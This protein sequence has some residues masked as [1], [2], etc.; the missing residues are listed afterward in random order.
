MATRAIETI[1]DA[2]SETSDLRLGDKGVAKAN[3]YVLDDSVFNTPE[4]GDY[5]IGAVDTEY[6]KYLDSFL[7]GPEKA[8]AKKAAYYTE[9]P[10]TKN[11]GYTDDK[12]AVFFKAEV[13]NNWNTVDGGWIN[14]DELIIK[15]GS[16]STD[17]NNSKEATEA[18]AKFKQDLFAD[19]KKAEYDQLNDSDYFT[20]GLYGITSCK[21][22]KWAYESNVP[23]GTFQ[24][25]DYTVER[26]YTLSDEKYNEN[27]LGSD[28][29]IHKIHDDGE[30]LHVVK[31]GNV[32][33]EMTYTDGNPES[34]TSSFRW[35]I[36]RGEANHEAAF[37]AAKKMSEILSKV[38]NTVYIM[39]D[40]SNS[41]TPYSM[42][43]NQ[44][45]LTGDVVRK[46]YPIAESKH[47]ALNGYCLARM[48]L[49]GK[50]LGSAYVKIDGKWCN[51]AKMVLAETDD[52]EAITDAD[53]VTDSDAFK[54]D[55]NEEASEWADAF[56]SLNDEI[57]DRKAIQA[58]IFGKNWDDLSKWTVTLGD[59][60][61][62]APPT[63]ITVVS[64]TEDE[65]IPLMRANGSMS[66]MGKR[67]IRAITMELYFTK[68]NEGVNGY[69]YKTKMPN[70]KPI[71]YYMNG[72]RALIAQFKFT[73]FL[74]IENE[75]INNTLGIE[76]V[77]FNNMQINNI[78]RMPGLYH[79]TISL[80]E[81]DYAVYMP[82]LITLCI[83]WGCES[84]YF[85][86]AFNWPVF[87]YYYQRCI[88]RGNDFSGLAFNSDEYNKKIIENRTSLQPMDFTDS[89]IKFYVADEEYL[90][91]MWQAKMNADMG[92]STKIKLTDNDKKTAN[93]VANLTNSLVGALNDDQIKD[94]LSK[95]KYIYSDA[96][97]P[98]NYIQED[99]RDVFDKLATRITGS[100]FEPLEIGDFKYSMQ[101]KQ[102]KNGSP[103]SIAQMT[104]SVKGG[105]FSNKDE[106]DKFKKACAMNM[107]IA[108]VDF[109]KDGKITLNFVSKKNESGEF[110]PYELET[111]NLDMK[112][113]AFCT[114][115]KKQE[116]LLGSSDDTETKD[117]WYINSSVASL[118]MMKFTEYPT[119]T[120]Y[121]NQI[122][123]GLTNQ[124][125]SIHLA[126]LDGASPQYMGGQDIQ[127][128]MEIVTS[129][130]TAVQALT[131]LP[132]FA[133]SQM[134]KYRQIIP[135]YPVRI[136]SE[137]T[138]FLG[139]TDVVVE[140][141][142][143]STVE[144]I[145]GVYTITLILTSVDRTLRQREAMAMLDARNE[146]D[147]AYSDKQGWATTKSYFDIEESIAKS[148]LYPDLE[149]PTLDEMESMGWKFTRYKFQDE[150]IYVDPD[151]YILYLT[152]LTSEMIRE[153]VLKSVE[154]DVGTGFKLE[155]NTGAAVEV[156]MASEKG[157]NVVN[158]NAE[159][160]AQHDKVKQMQDAQKALNAKE[161]KENLM[162]QT[163]S[164][165]DNV[166]ETW[167]ICS[168]IKCMFLEKKYKKEYDSYVAQLKSNAIKNGTYDP[169]KAS[170]Y[171]MVQQS[172]V[173][174]L[175]KL[176][177][178]APSPESEQE[179]PSEPGQNSSPK[180]EDDSVDAATLTY[181]DKLT[182]NLKTDDKIAEGKWVATKLEQARQASQKIADYLQNTPIDESCILNTGTDPICIQA[183]RLKA[184]SVPSYDEYEDIK[185]SSEGTLVEKVKLEIYDTTK[186]FLLSS[187]ISTL[188]K[189]LPIY[190]TSDFIEVFQ[191]IIYAS[192]C[193]ATGE[194]EFSA[195]EKSMNWKP[196]ATFIGT[197]NGGKQDT[198]IDNDVS[199]IDDG[200]DKAITFGAFKIKMYD[201]AE[202]RRITGK[203]E[204][205]ITL[206]DEIK[207]A[208]PVNTSYYLLDPYYR[209][210]NDNDIEKIK[211]YKRNCMTSIP[212]C[213]IAFM[214]L[215]LYWI[216]RM[217]DRQIYP[218]FISDVLR[219]TS[220]AE[221]AVIDKARKESVADEKM[222]KMES[223]INLYKKNAYC[224]DA[225]K[226]WIASLYTLTDGDIK[227]DKRIQDR[228][229]R[230]LDSYI[231]G[232]SV[233]RKKVKPEDNSTMMMRKMILS[234]VG[235]GRVE[236]VSALGVPQDSPVAQKA[237]KLMQQKY[238]QM[239][240]DPK[241]YTIHSCHD[242]IVN[243]A[244]GRLLRAFPTYYMTII[245]EGRTLGSYKLHDNFYNNMAISE[246]EVVKSRKLPAD[247]A[248]I[249]MSNVYMTFTN[250]NEDMYDPGTVAAGTST[251][252]NI[253]NTFSSIF[254]PTSFGEEMEQARQN[255]GAETKLLLR[256]GARIHLRMGYGS[257]ASMVPV[258]FNGSIA[259][260]NTG[261]V[262]E[263]VAQGDGI[264]LVNP[265]MEDM[266]AHDIENNDDFFNGSTIE[267]GATP[268]EIM[269]ALLTTNGG[270]WA[271]FL[272]TVGR[273]DLLGRNPYGIYHFGNPDFKTIFE[274][275][276]TT[277]NIF[278]ADKAPSIT[279]DIFGKTVW[280]IANICKSVTPDHICAV[281]PFGFRSTL[282]IGAYRYYYAYD[283]M[284]S[285][286]LITEKR[287]PFQQY[288][289]YSS[290]TDI[291]GNGMTATSRDMKTN[292][293]GLYQTCASL[294]SVEQ[295]RVGPLYADIDI[296]PDCQKSMIVDTQLL[297]KGVPIVGTV[298]N[299]LTSFEC[300][301]SLFDDEGSIVSHEKIAWK[302]TASALR[303]SMMD[304]YA[305]D[306]VVLG[307][308]SVKPH[309]R[310]RISDTYEAIDGQCLVKEV[311]HH[312][313]VDQGFITT[314]TPDCIVAIDD[315]FEKAT[316]AFYS[317]VTGMIVPALLTKAYMMRAK[318][319]GVAWGLK[320]AWSIF[321]PSKLR[322]VMS[323]F[324]GKEAV[325]KGLSAAK[326]TASKYASKVASKLA[327]QS[328]IKQAASATAAK[329][330]ARVGVKA[331][332]KVGARALL[333]TACAA[334][335]G[336][337]GLAIF[338]AI[339]IGT[340][341]VTN[342]IE[343]YTKNL[344]VAHVYPLKHYGKVWTAGLDGSK[345]M[346]AGS[347]TEKQQGGMSKFLSTV[348]GTDENT[349][350]F[351][352]LIK[353][354]LFGEDLA[355]TA[356][357]LNRDQDENLYVEADNN[358]S[359]ITD[360][361]VDYSF[362][363]VLKGYSSH[364]NLNE[365]VR[366]D[367]RKMQTVPRVNYD[368]QS[369]LASAFDSF[370][371]QEPEKYQDDPKLQNNKHI[372][373]DERLKPYIKEGFFKII[374]ETPA[375]NTGSYVDS[376]II[377]LN[378]E[379]KYIKVI[380]QRQEDGS[381]AYDMPLLHVDAMNIL[382]EI[383][384]RAKNAMPSANSS[385]PQET[386]EENKNS[387]VLLESALRVGDKNSQASTGFTFIL[388]GVEKAAQ[389]LA[390]A[391]SELYEEIKD[392]S[393]KN[394]M[395]NA[396]LF[397]SKDLGDNKTAISV[398][399][400]KISSSG[401]NKNT[402]IQEIQ[403]H[404]SE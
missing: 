373:D 338:A 347:P 34:P 232:C 38:N 363:D 355:N 122:E 119:G 166:I 223:T 129:D 220:E 287:K 44:G 170:D 301:D 21:T 142:E 11:C 67:T 85:S 186:K 258:V 221:L 386:Y 150:R 340:S 214:R 103:V 163:N 153:S 333:G 323:D 257:N 297:G 156:A 236:E 346:I 40:M 207:Q 244:R 316:N 337:V 176:D 66:K 32:W 198:A 162:R 167:N 392:A 328:I 311:I 179:S 72:L 292:A 313:S 235:V 71:T 24:V 168:D 217:F 88:M 80:T 98:E 273:P 151:F 331:G 28:Q 390:A 152:R 263:I 206:S 348:M 12:S 16:L 161:L 368:N 394:P 116:D 61:L 79:V 298:T 121:V 138:R 272:K 50:R 251:W 303:E 248:H 184:S 102:D 318:K 199:D 242:M 185:E 18:L 310:L 55:Y 183:R 6:L 123:A 68:D 91:T 147:D 387:F 255:K 22:P 228:D 397:D 172:E 209:L 2:V 27:S 69:E 33:R 302:M 84:N 203:A 134:K 306:I 77:V 127:L 281:A 213:T 266:K 26:D 335:G 265:I 233:P 269:T 8:D 369:E 130:K 403:P 212:Y 322:E 240:E 13:L 349:G 126:E 237:R 371:M 268:K 342:A 31:I 352:G 317:A 106:L 357:K 23:K 104:F 378:G 193:S 65:R 188:L 101:K 143:A 187:E 15:I 296:F 361:N 169:S 118:A 399:M 288:H 250:E 133:T 136:N 381:I 383:I 321:T 177:E 360:K 385:D 117:G 366:N 227:I 148:E 41:N 181:A 25:S 87:R 229:Y 35:C 280:D 7:N 74:P 197:K 211:T 132:K 261:E 353:D 52:K 294:N 376:H 159:A 86:T 218:S 334:L 113:L 245:D 277:Q 358:S 70:G 158:R 78:E 82:E 139:I 83:S 365:T 115:R 141:V 284:K 180:P 73:P 274:N 160:Q 270:W 351:E 219:E 76:A 204:S 252:D 124:V 99:I 14:G 231:Y 192:A 276:E 293:I 128:R 60:T 362:D 375:L 278:E 112:F 120:L 222:A 3:M 307:D 345:G 283:Y 308:P 114:Q 48:E 289:F 396:S 111:D 339:S 59:V 145:P 140:N 171:D 64:H 367:Y 264:E 146:T 109:V 105:T 382:Y 47:G 149:L 191:D 195:K 224:I 336:P 391:I 157:I 291:I 267:N 92:R 285:N 379:D 56:K 404:P 384:R 49:L 393:A 37:K 154:N 131:N 194:K 110:G 182:N 97:F 304:M 332:I 178:E 155:D 230:A 380:F 108:S 189:F 215:M 135:S 165:E 364:G 312:M 401:N 374:H 370:S 320:S 315:D 305:G 1:S 54:S 314:V 286:G 330:V 326:G 173:D 327:T 325:Q 62:M 190:C 290:M 58:K 30:S 329:A 137:I 53:F 17:G 350:F 216:M 356:G 256:P 239:A 63:N 75:Y 260:I 309:D 400:P 9:P 377:K 319:L 144:R 395:L 45:L 254:T 90:Q 372:S 238:I 10:A 262:V 279:F 208:N 96:K 246:I 125:T 205:T 282:F 253:K 398:R 46:L 174:K 100:K 93:G 354:V 241:Q 29:I 234:L 389:P 259:E 402:N 36:N 226:M 175:L 300:I 271:T 42:M 202:F 89:G 51:L 43:N 388:R 359:S 324:G 249:V 164:L 5:Y 81:F 4:M 20:L 196:S 210:S 107:G 19:P 225:G 243:D 341:L 57:D 295:H 299:A 94:E 275:G 200:V 344:E 343:R 39:V 95:T 201:D 247:T